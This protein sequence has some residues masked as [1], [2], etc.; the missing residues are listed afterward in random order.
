MDYSRTASP[1]ETLRLLARLPTSAP[2]QRT[3]AMFR[4]RTRSTSPR[5]RS[6]AHGLR[7][8]KGAS[9]LVDGVNV[10]H[11]V[12]AVLDKMGRLLRP[13]KRRRLERATRGNRSAMWSTS[14][15]AAPTSA[16][17]MAYEALKHYSDRRMTFRFV[18]NVERHGLRRGGA[19]PRP[20]PKPSLSSPPRRL[21][22]WR[23]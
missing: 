5:T 19:R 2:A 6:P 4:G 22:R 21:P 1:D 12:H 20:P 15:S 11:E 18:S 10:V 23:R 13:R 16:P 7:A 3:D 9:I 17:S 8:P 14:A